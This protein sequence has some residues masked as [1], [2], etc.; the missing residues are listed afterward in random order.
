VGLTYDLVDVDAARPD[1]DIW[2]ARRALEHA[3]DAEEPFEV[4]F[5]AV[6]TYI[7]QRPVASAWEDRERGLS[8]ADTCAWRPASARASR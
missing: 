7:E 5:D 4:A 2:L 1:G 8:S 3:R 6:L